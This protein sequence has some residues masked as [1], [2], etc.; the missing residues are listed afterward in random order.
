MRSTVDEVMLVSDE[1]IVG[2]M[3]MLFA[4]AAIV[5]EPAGAA[6]LAAMTKRKDALTGKQVATPLTGGNITSEQ[7]RTWLL[8]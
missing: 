4:A 6:G 5:V 8:D 2:A 1:E 3:K 7:I